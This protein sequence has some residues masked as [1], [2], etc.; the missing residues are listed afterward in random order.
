VSGREISFNLT[1][2]YDANMN[3]TP[4]L[5]EGVEDVGVAVYDSTTNELL[6]FGYTDENGTVRFSALTVSGTIRISIPFLQFDQL[7]TGESDILIRVAPTL[8]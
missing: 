3:F 4:E 6:A 2:Y 5:P 1:V 8:R 7:A